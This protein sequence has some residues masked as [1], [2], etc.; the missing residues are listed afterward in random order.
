MKL[1]P[2]KVFN[3]F[4]FSF[5]PEGYHSSDWVTNF[6]G[7]F[8]MAPDGQVCFAWE[9]KGFARF[10]GRPGKAGKSRLVNS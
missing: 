5:S 2:K 6:S 9:G 7:K 3:F 4:F 1:L 10:G 8:N